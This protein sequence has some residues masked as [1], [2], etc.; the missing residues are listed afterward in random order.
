[1]TNK[2]NNILNTI[3]SKFKSTPL[4]LSLE[5][6]NEL[7]NLIENHNLKNLNYFNLATIIISIILFL[8]DFFLIS[9]ISKELFPSHGYILFMYIFSIVIL[10]IFGLLIYFLNYNKKKLK[11]NYYKTLFISNILTF[12]FIT[13]YYN[14]FELKDFNAGNTLVIFLFI[15][16]ILFRFSIKTEL[17]IVSL[18]TLIYFILLEKLNFNF[19]A[20]PMVHLIGLVSIILYLL[21]ATV[22]SKQT[23][24]RFL[25][26]ILLQRKNT[27]LS[28]INDQLNNSQQ[29]IEQQNKLLIESNEKLSRFAYMAAHD[30]KGPLRTTKSLLDILYSK[31]NLIFDEE[32]KPLLEH[33]MKSSKDLS[34]L[35]SNLL[36]FSTLTQKLPEPEIVD[37][38]E[39][40]K[41][42]K[43]S[44]QSDIEKYNIE[45]II[46][47]ELENLKANPNLIYQLFVNLISNSIKFGKNSENKKIIIEST[48]LNNNCI[49]YSIQ[50]FGIGIPKEKQQNV[51][52]LFYKGHSKEQYSGTGIG[53]SICK[54]IVSYYD[55]S[56]WFETIPNVGTTF[57]FKLA[58][59]K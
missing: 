49:Q 56:I 54:K 38:H 13:T 41:D 55:G 36:L 20:I 30:L 46:N 37:I 23:I 29:K 33:V 3:F 17:V 43:N 59:K 28:L 15:I 19:S 14:Y 4:D 21:L 47:K 27:E 51:F 52:D 31:Y 32:D 40:I 1:M 42:I 39:I 2:I 5:E 9:D 57:Y 8:I 7:K 6:V 35:V 48:K 26:E 18:Y 45:L 22:I 16:A 50:D 34:N 53:L 24:K 58:M 25:N 11:I 12:F 10:S 44:L